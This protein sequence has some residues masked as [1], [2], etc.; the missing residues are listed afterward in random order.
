MAAW[1]SSLGPL[2]AS[3]WMTFPVGSM[4]TSTC[5]HPGISFAASG[6]TGFAKAS[7]VKWGT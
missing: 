5:T 6:T 3:A 4:V 1:R 7:G 2:R